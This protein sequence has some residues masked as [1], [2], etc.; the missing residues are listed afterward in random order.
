MEAEE[1]G[2][3]VFSINGYDNKFIFSICM[4]MWY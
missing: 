2:M 3:E 4:Y 1:K